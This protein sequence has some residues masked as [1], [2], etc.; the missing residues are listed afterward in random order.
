[1]LGFAPIATLPIA[2]L[3]SF[4]TPGD[5]VTYFPLCLNVDTRAFMALHV[6]HEAFMALDV[7]H[8]LFM[9]LKSKVKVC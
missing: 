8:R 1:M 4:V 2:A 6:G 3:P 7:D 5:F 9:P